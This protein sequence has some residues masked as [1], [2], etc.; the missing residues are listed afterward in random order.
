M[1]G[2]K[3]GRWNWN[4]VKG[5]A[6]E[7]ERRKLEGYED[8]LPPYGSRASR[9][10]QLKPSAP[11][12]PTKEHSTSDVPQFSP[13]ARPLPSKEMQAR[14]LA[15]EARLASLTSLI[16]QLIV[17]QQYTKP[18]PNTDMKLWAEDD[19]WASDDEIKERTP[20]PF[21]DPDLGHDSVMEDSSS[22]SD[23]T[24]KVSIP[25]LEPD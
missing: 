18:T 20:L 1:E 3:E 21:S 5:L 25:S 19:D 7:A 24:I 6:R 10:N 4:E 13:A 11:K 8:I 22:E 17:E 2:I 14:L 15:N 12:P 16:S 9:L 23:I